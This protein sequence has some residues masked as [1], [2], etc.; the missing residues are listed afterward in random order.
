MLT[1]SKEVAADLEVQLL[2]ELYL[3]C[4]HE[5]SMIKLLQKGVDQEDRQGEGEDHLQRP[6]GPA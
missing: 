3:N 1:H 2:F 5:K 6:P 4:K